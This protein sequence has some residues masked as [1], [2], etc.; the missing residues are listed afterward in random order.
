M[1]KLFALHYPAGFF[2]TG[3]KYGGAIKS[4]WAVSFDGQKIYEYTGTLRGTLERIL[5]DK[6]TH[7]EWDLLNGIIARCGN[8]CPITKEYLRH[9]HC[10]NCG[11]KIINIHEIL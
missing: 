6:L 1:K 7:R 9:N 10:L 2:L 11:D 5:S 3:K 8:G 4:R